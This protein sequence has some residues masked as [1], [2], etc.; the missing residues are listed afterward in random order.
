[1][2]DSIL[3]SIKKVIGINPSETAFDLDLKMHINSALNILNQ[4][5]IGTIG[6]TISDSTG[7]WSEFVETNA[8]QEMVRSYVCLKVRLIFDP[9]TSG[10][11][12]ESFKEQLK[13]LEWRMFVN[14][15]PNMG[16]EEG[17]DCDCL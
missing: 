12:T 8:L 16:S 15:D 10:I 14:N 1:M 9:P 4:M 17:D 2:D 11:V 6:F 5:G 3:L 7:K 13:E